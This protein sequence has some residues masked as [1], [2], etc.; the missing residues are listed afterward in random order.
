LRVVD[1]GGKEVAAK[2]IDGVFPSQV[3]ADLGKI[4]ETGYYAVYT[5]LYTPDGKLIMNYPA[6]GFSVVA[7]A[8][9]QKQRLGKKKLW[10]NDYYALADGDKSFK[11]EGGYF[12]WLERMGIYQSYGSYPGFDSQYRTKWEKAKQLGLVLF[13]DSS[14]DSSWLN[15]NPAD[16]Q[17]FTN[18]ASAFTRYFKATNEI[19]IRHEAEWQKLREP[20]HW[21]ERAKWEYE[22]AH[23]QLS[24]A[25][26]VGG[27][28]VR[29]GEDQWFKQALELELDRYQDAWDVHAYPQKEPRFGG[30]IGNGENEDERG[31]LATYASLD[32]KNSLPFWLGE[33]GAKAMHGLTGRRW[34]AEQAAKMIAWVNSRNDYLGLAFC[35]GHEYDLAYGRIWD[36]S[37]GHKPGEAALYTASALIDGLPYK[38]VDTKDG[39]IQAAYFGETLMVW[40]TD[41]ASGNW[42]LKLDHGKPWVLVDVVGQVRELPTDSSG[43]ADIPIS[44][45]PVY[46][47]ARADYERLTRK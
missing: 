19:D 35:I 38:A 23:K 15:D 44:A 21:V 29:P 24:D 1:Y 7:G 5:S 39:N 12:S 27:S 46:V 42:P 47:L 36:Y 33:T 6:D 3:E 8:A 28:L 37:M 22:Q 43:N 13:A 18:A 34:Q 45:S 40:R 16:G 11:Q 41:E 14:G 10:N 2:D 30:P 9:E 31:V 26:Y 32:R 20:A 25:H 4:S 17:N